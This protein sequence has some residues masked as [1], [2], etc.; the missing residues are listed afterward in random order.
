MRGVIVLAVV[1]PY[2]RRGLPVVERE[3]LRRDERAVEAVDDYEE[4]GRSHHQPESVY[5]LGR[6]YYP[7]YDAEGYGKGKREYGYYEGG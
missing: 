6:V 1:E 3:Y 4:A 7:G 5:A 2:C